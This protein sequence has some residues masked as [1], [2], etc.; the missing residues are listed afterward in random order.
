M[1]NILIVGP[2]PPPFGGVASHLNDLIPSL[3]SKG[4]NITT[5]T[6]SKKDNLKNFETHKEIRYSINYFSFKTAL[7]FIQNFVSNI[8]LKKDLPIRKFVKSIFF[9]NKINSII[10]IKNID[11]IF[12]YTIENGYTIP[13][14]RSKFGNK[15]KIVLMIFGAFYLNPIKYVK[16]KKY[17]ASVFKGSN[18]ITSS[19]YYCGCSIFDVL[20]LKFSVEV[21]YIGVD[22][23]KYIST[24]NKN[25]LREKF[26]IPS[27]AIVLLFFARMEKSMGLDFVIDNLTSILELNKNVHIIIAG[28]VG[29]LS[30]QAKHIS[31]SNDRVKYFCNIPFEEKID[32]YNV[33]NFLMAPTIEKHACMGVSIKEAMSCEIPVIASNSG[34]IPE[35]IV[36]GKNGF[37]VQTKDGKLVKSI[38]L[39]KLKKIIHEKDDLNQIGKNGRKTVV[40][41]FSNNTT[42]KKYL[43]LINDLENL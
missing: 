24:E 22:Q 19:S 7:G 26:N 36:D 3:A 17:L 1:K 12:I 29:K 15:V 42:T 40:K 34:G 41:L 32:F 11:I 4:F 31:L 6:S 20:N 35:A 8:F 2:V 5:I 23:H 14:I 16:E 13:M 30:T 37:L 9:S 38:F 39:N 28:A 33:S 25:L 27:S 21:I 18:K 43:D 10:Q